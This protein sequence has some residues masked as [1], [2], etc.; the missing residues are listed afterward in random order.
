[1]KIVVIGG[2]GLIGK[3]LVNML[4]Q[5]GHDVLAASPSSGVDT[6]TGAGLA[7]ALKG[8]HV[9]VDTSNSPSFEDAAVLK[10]FETSARNIAAA[11][12]TAGVQHHVALSVVG[13]DRM[14]SSGYM[15]AKVAQ[16]AIIKA[17]GVPY[18]ILR[19][20]QFYEFLAT[21]A[22]FSQKD[23]A[24][25]LPQALMQPLAADDVVAALAKVVT[26]KPVND[27]IEIAG[28]KKILMAEIVQKALTAKHDPRKVVSDP[29]A[30]YFGYQ[31]DDSSL[32]PGDP[33]AQIGPTR[34][35]DWLSKTA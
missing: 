34:F 7:E 22:D 1:M 21:I 6:L 23:G 17:S 13:A 26:G 2:S 15:R 9:V 31:I 4:R 29:N 16:E 11:E 33:T 5:Q 27:I 3:K 12:V 28:P 18:T 14:G 20:T 32:T 24:I 10:F 8:A 19:A 35:E 30:G 25:R